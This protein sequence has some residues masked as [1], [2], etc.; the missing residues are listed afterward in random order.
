MLDPR[1]H[2]LWLAEAARGNPPP[3]RLVLEEQ[4]GLVIDWWQDE[5][6][7]PLSSYIDPDSD[8]KTLVEIEASRGAGKSTILA[9]IRLYI[10]EYVIPFL[11]RTGLPIRSENRHMVLFGRD[12]KHL[13][14]DILGPMAKL[15]IE[16][17]PWLRTPEWLALIEDV[18]NPSNEGLRTLSELKSKGPQKWEAL[19]LDL[20]NGVSIRTR[21]LRQSVRGLHVFYADMDDPLTES[22]A[23]ESGDILRLILGSILPALEPGGIFLIAGTPQ[24]PGDLFDLIASDSVPLTEPHLLLTA[25]K[26]WLS[27][28]YPAYDVDQSRGYAA[29]NQKRHPDRTFTKEDLLCLWPSRLS[30]AALEQARGNTAESE[31]KFQREYLLERS[32]PE[33]RLVRDDDLL[34]AR[35]YTLSYEPRNNTGHEV[36][37]GCDPSGRKKDA[38]GLVVGYVRP[39]AVRIPLC[40]SKLDV[41]PHLPLGEGELSVVQEMNDLTERYGCWRWVVESNG[42]QA[43]IMPLARQLNPSIRPEPFQLG[44]N[45]HTENGWLGLRTIFRNRLVRLPYKT[46]EDRRITDEFIFQ[47]RGLQF[48][49]G[50]VEEDRRRKNDLVSAFFL[51]LK[52]C[53]QTAAVYEATAL[54]SRSR[55]ESEA[56]AGSVPLPGPPPVDPMS[57]LRG[58]SRPADRGEMA[59]PGD[60]PRDPWS[61]SSLRER[62]SRR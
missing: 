61:A 25:K 32:T 23:H 21:T 14:D 62:L 57:V 11:V 31:V 5:A 34:A 53:E 37:G 30:W 2:D 26:S 40:M 16:C 52:A 56:V 49:E 46:E 27:G 10:A 47:V 60:R 35:D 39:D 38:A 51:W 41:M 58:S 36:S 15:V 43:V 33:T 4:Y 55:N 13:R 24:L 6:V 18:D 54:T 9:G 48:I 19:R 42:A 45:K 59:R 20:T 7:I 12:E 44:A 22:N 1:V 3:P 17:A 29:K 8:I 50:K 28:R